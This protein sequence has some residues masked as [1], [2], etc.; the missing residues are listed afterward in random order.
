MILIK[1]IQIVDGSGTAPYRADVILQGDKISAIGN[2]PKKSADV[3][4][5]GLGLHLTPGFI[6]VNTDSDHYL[7]LFSNPSQKDFLLQGVTTIIG[8]NCGSSLAPLLYGSL[9][10]IRKWADADL[11]NI[12]WSTVAELK[13]TLNRL[14]IGVNFATLAGH[15]TI[16]RDLIGEEIRD[17]T[18][19]ELEVFKNTLGQAIR[20][21]ALG[22]STGLGYS[23]SRAVSRFEIKNL[24]D[25]VAK[26]NGVYATHLRN[27]KE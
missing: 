8:G 14:K 21:G 9:K 26:N 16:R 10:S 19:S 7:S 2:F 1:G 11:I 24:L 18:V 3:V 25:S 15:S 5:E 4:I 13:N 12:N 6:D 20:E 22:L 27:E 23:H 17:L